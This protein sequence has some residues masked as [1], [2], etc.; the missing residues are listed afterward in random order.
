MKIYLTMQKNVTVVTKN[1]T[2]YSVNGNTGITYR[3]A[4]LNGD[5]VEKIKCIN[6]EVYEQFL[7]GSSYLLTGELDIRNGSMSE[8]KVNGYVPDAS[9][10]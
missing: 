3:L 1:E 7:V 4:I 9:K 10:K 8:F 5:D 2:P 6:K